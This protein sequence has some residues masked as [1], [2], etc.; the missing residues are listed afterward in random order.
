[1]ATIVPNA[2]IFSILSILAER[3][4]FLIPSE[5]A[6]G[7]NLIGSIEDVHQYL[8]PPWMPQ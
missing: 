1:V 8:D 2:N 4:S 3:V 6:L 7:V 5:M